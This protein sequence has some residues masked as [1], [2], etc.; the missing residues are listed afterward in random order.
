MA[1]SKSTTSKTAKFHLHVEN[2]TRLNEVFES[3]PKRVR[4]ALSRFPDLKDRVR[5]TIGCGG[6]NLEKNLVK[7]DALFCHRIDVENIDERAPKLKWIHVHA[8]GVE[9][10]MPLDW[11]PTRMT[12]MNSSGVHGRR[13][14]EYAAT[15][16]LMLNNR[17]PELVTH[18]Q[19]GR[20]QQCFNSNIGGKTLL[21]VGVGNIGGDIARWAKTMDMNVLGIRR[22]GGKNRYVDE[23]HKTDKLRKLLPRAD[24]VL[25]AAPLTSETEG[26]VGKTELDL[27][28]Q[29]AGFVNYSRARVVDYGH[30]I[31]KLK[32]GEISAVLDVFDPEPLPSTSPL[33][34][35]PNLI[36]T[37]HCG[38]DDS[39]YY[40]PRTLDIVLNNVRRCLD[41]KKL[42]NTV[43]RELQ[44]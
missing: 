17:I 28:K 1:K 38:S 23:M 2:S 18:Q 35:T 37:P 43:S 22:S 19:A 20:W 25:I 41:G 3:S 6:D 34:K 30:L 32:R 24:F 12:L 31:K 11:L 13:A 4:E 21:I 8:A 29:G 42:T 14:T 33:W 9:H 16:I 40:T 44:Y 26:L 27:L 15:A 36:I 10:L 39:T 5:V 7:A